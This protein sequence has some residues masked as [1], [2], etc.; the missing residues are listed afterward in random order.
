M[1]MVMMVIVMKHMRR[2]KREERGE[3]EQ[4]NNKRRESN[5]GMAEE[6]VLAKATGRDAQLERER[7]KQE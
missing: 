4:E 3:K 5:L 7:M 6:G 2:E 1:M